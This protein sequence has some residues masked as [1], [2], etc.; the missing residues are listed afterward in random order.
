MEVAP[1]EKEV[2]IN[3]QWAPIFLV[4]KRATSIRRLQSSSESERFSFV[5][6]YSFLLFFL[7]G[8]RYA[9]GKD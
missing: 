4:S 6:L 1:T 7:P 8:S 2:S 9:S 5:L 3:S